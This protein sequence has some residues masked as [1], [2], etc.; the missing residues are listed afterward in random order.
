M[1][2]SRTDL[3]IREH[4]VPGMPQA[5]NAQLRGPKSL[6]ELIEICASRPAGIRLKASGSHW[7]LSD[8]AV[9]D[10]EYIETNDPSDMQQHKPNAGFHALGRTLFNVVPGCL[11]PTALQDL[12]RAAK[13]NP[14][15]EPYYVHVESG[16]RIYQLYSELD[17]GDDHN[18]NS[19]AFKMNAE[20]RNPNF[21]GSWAFETL[22]GA[23]GQTIVG[24]LTT[25]THGGDVHLPPVSDSVRAIH[26]VVD[27]GKHYWIEPERPSWIPASLKGQPYN[28]TFT[29]DQ[30][31]HGLF[32]QTNLG[33][34]KQL[35]AKFRTPVSSKSS[36]T[37]TRLTQCWFRQAGSALFT[38]VLQAVRQYFLRKCDR[39]GLATVKEALLDPTNP[40]FQTNR[41]V[42]IAIC[43]TPHDNGTKNKCGIT[44]RDLAPPPPLPDLKLMPWAWRQPRAKHG[45]CRDR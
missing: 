43:L 23:G 1:V 18:S 28:A 15:N 31:L 27:G 7:A 11:N 22:G 34:D 45:R 39:S 37:T 30:Q 12:D 19:L 24:A 36:A 40:I 38:P 9:S 26:L 41:F 25:G 42:Q 16:K 3:W 6:N 13:A 44:V 29:S 20:F 17:V 32:D 10:G 5:S 8:A 21:A 35:I 4:D 14:H 33:L 2:D